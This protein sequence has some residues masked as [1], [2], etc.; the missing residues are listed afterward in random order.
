[1][2]KQPASV[3]AAWLAPPGSPANVQRALPPPLHPAAALQ[4]PTCRR[5]VPSPCGVL[6]L[7]AAARSIGS[8]CAAAAAAARRHRKQLGLHRF[9]VGPGVSQEGVGGGAGKQVF[10]RGR[11]AAVSLL[12]FRRRLARLLRIPPRAAAAAARRS[13]GLHALQLGGQQLVAVGGQAGLQAHS[14]VLS[15]LAL[16]RDQPLLLLRVLLVACGRGGAAKSLLTKLT[17]LK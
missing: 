4:P 11:S 1:M 15:F 2:R 17:V 8:G 12:P 5:L 9:E 10:L 13:L 16:P 14:R 7:L 6:A 3:G